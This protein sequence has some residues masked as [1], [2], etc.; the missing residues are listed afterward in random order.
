[1]GKCEGKRAVGRRPYQWK[2]N[3]RTCTKRSLSEHSHT[4]KFSNPPESGETTT[5]MER[6][7]SPYSPSEPDTS[8][9][10][11]GRASWQQHLHRPAV[12]GAHSPGCHHGCTIARKYKGKVE[13]MGLGNY[14]AASA[15]WKLLLLWT[16]KKHLY[17]YSQHH[18]CFGQCFGVVISV[19]TC[20]R[21]QRLGPGFKLA[22]TFKHLFMVWPMNRLGLHPG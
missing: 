12:D 16:D 19:Y 21:G 17:F 18:K 2:D 22:K 20:S 15:S 9:V 6:S 10:Q 1:M 8:L 11:R 14:L 7:P 3:F 4:V 13:Y 5:F